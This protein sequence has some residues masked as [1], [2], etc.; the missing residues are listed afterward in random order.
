M[1]NYVRFKLV[2]SAH[3]VSSGVGSYCLGCRVIIRSETFPEG[4]LNFIIINFRF[5]II[6]GS[7]LISWNVRKLPCM[8]RIFVNFP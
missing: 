4:I 7:Y 8:V 5:I 3:I 1:V 6:I 2:F